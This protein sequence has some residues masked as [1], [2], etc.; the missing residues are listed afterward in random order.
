MKAPSFLPATDPEGFDR[1][2]FHRELPR[3]VRQFLDSQ[4]KLA[5]A[6]EELP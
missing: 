1:E 2:Q 6:L 5:A 3:E 4:L